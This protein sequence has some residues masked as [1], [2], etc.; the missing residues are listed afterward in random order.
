MGIRS[1]LLFILLLLLPALS[2]CKREPS[3]SAAAERGETAS[4]PSNRVDVPEMVRRN[5]GITFAK[6]ESRHVARTIR[7]PGSFELSPQARR[8]VRTMLGGQV[9]LHVS[10]FERVETGRLLYTL[11]SPQW[12]ELQERLNET[13]SQLLQARARAETIDPLMAAHEQHHDELMNGVKIWTERVAQ[14]DQSRGSGV[15][16][17]EEFA[18]ARAALATTRAEM[19]EVMEKEAELHSRRIEVQAQASAAQERFELLI[20]NAASLLG[21]ATDQLLAI[22]PKSAQQH[23][24]WREIKLVEVRA[25]APGV[26]ESIAL[27]SGA[28]AGETNLVLTTIQP[29]RLRFRARGL[30]S[31]LNRL[32]DGLAGRIVPP[33]GSVP[34][35]DGS[36]EGTITLGLSADADERTVELFMT[37]AK[38]SAWARP[39]VA[40]HLEIVA[41][42]AAAAELAIPVSAT[43]RDGL[44]TVVFRRDPANPDKV[45]RIEADLGVSDGNWVVISSGVREGDEVVLDGVYPLMLASSGTS[46]KGGHFHADGTWHEGDK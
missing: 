27:T 11:D 32:R 23:P 15:V 20:S 6:V 42:G 2:G 43:I 16:T 44:Q 22:D 41:V 21:L 46:Q 24:R 18:E 30:Q 39:G 25:A 34:A 38:L 29:E 3:N 37:P 7:V 10:Q 40:A 33:K 26:V 1:I 36:M 28:W 8:E 14:L 9:E 4:A 35:L 13:E 45:I 5:L 17:D 19:A 12:R 31:D